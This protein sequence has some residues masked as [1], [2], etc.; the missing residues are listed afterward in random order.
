MNP[1]LEKI[2][3]EWEK[4]ELEY[5][6]YLKS[7]MNESKQ[8]QQTFQ[9]IKDEEVLNIGILYMYFNLMVYCM[10]FIV[11]YIEDREIKK[12]KFRNKIEK[13]NYSIHELD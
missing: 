7:E 9:K 6:E 2:F 4:E 10:R 13:P 8:I 11:F 5:Q 12:R 1:E 3:D